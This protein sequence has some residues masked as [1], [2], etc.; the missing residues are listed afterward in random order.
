MLPTTA[1]GRLPIN[2]VGTQLPT[3]GKGI[4]GRMSD[5][6]LHDAPHCHAPIHKHFDNIRACIRLDAKR[7]SE[8]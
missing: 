7:S 3:I 1:A 6:T 8:L 4:G 5:L 2:T